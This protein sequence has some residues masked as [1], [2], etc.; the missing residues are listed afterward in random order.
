M[1]RHTGLPRN[2]NRANRGMQWMPDIQQRPIE[3]AVDDQDRVNWEKYSDH[4]RFHRD[5]DGFTT[6]STSEA[7]GPQQCSK[8]KGIIDT[9][10]E[11]CQ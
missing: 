10:C 7:T 9:M 8:K 5:H 2:A 1:N 11:V 3:V 4:P 6:D